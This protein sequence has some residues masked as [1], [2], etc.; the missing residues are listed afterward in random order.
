MEVLMRDLIL[1]LGGTV[2]ALT[3]AVYTVYITSLAV[4][5]VIAAMK[6]PA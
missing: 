4:H 5:N 1:F 2:L 6:I 3:A